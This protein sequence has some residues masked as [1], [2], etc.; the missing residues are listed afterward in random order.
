MC[1]RIRIRMKKTY[2]LGRHV[3]LVWYGRKGIKDDNRRGLWIIPLEYWRCYD[4]KLDVV[5][6]KKCV[7]DIEER[8]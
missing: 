2:F 8:K 3:D 6:G 1:A 5:K 4:F 7:R